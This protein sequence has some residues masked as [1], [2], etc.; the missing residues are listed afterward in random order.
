MKNYFALPQSPAQ[1]DVIEAY[2]EVQRS[3]QSKLS[4]IIIPKGLVEI[5]FSFQTEKLF[6]KFNNNIDSIPRCFIQGVHTQPIQLYLSDSHRFFGVIL[7]PTSVKYIFNIKPSDI[8]NEVLDLSLVDLSLYS[9]WHRLSEQNNF[10]DRVTVFS[11]WLDHRLPVIND[12]EKAF[13]WFI[14]NPMDVDISVAELS[15]YFCFSIRQLSRKFYELTGM[16]TE[17]LLLY[18]K[19]LKALKL[20]HTTNLSLTEISYKCYFS[21]QSHFIKTFKRL[22]L[23]TPKEYR[24]RMSFLE[25]HIFEN[26]C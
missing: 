14:K 9:L 21:D 10:Y 1:R 13:D 22:S 5:I 20:M 11:D 6:F 26:V 16:N 19:Y 7:H 24:Q 8:A 18:R 15:S 17:Q 12:R 4:E 2:W 23:L 25:G 3:N